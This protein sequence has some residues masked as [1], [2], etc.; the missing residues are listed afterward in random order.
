M[1]AQCGQIEGIKKRC[2]KPKINLDF[3]DMN[4]NDEKEKED[5]VYEHKQQQLLS[6]KMMEY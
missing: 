4:I 1:L 5:M 3:L 6:E 2:A